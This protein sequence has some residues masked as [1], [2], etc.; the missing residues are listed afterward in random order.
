MKSEKCS[1][2]LYIFY[3]NNISTAHYVYNVQIDKYL[4]FTACCLGPQGLQFWAHVQYNPSAKRADGGT[5][6]AEGY[7]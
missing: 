2:S 5:G 1:V 7:K 4:R 6:G 3:F